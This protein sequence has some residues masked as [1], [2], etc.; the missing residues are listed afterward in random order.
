MLKVE[1]CRSMMGIV[2]MRA[3]RGR[4]RT[5]NVYKS[6]EGHV[7]CCA[8]CISSMQNIDVGQAVNTLSYTPRMRIRGITD[9]VLEEVHPEERRV[10]L[11]YLI[12][13]HKRIR[14]RATDMM[15]DKRNRKQRNVKKPQK[16]QRNK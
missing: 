3:R 1:I 5:Q 7:K 9:R 16:F 12:G 6:A 4:R 14:M 15:R 11:T 10:K 2:L 8:T 13:A